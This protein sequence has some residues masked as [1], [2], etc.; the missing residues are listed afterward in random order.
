MNLLRSMTGYGRGE[1]QCPGKKF[2]LEIKA[3][4]HRYREVVV[5]VPRYMTMLEDPIRKYVQEVVTR[6][7]VDVYCSVEDGDTPVNAVK[8]DKSLAVAYYKAID[9]LRRYLGLTADI[10]IEHLISQPGMFSANNV[11][12]D[13]TQWWPAIEEALLVACQSLV[14]MRE[15]EG[16]ALLADL[17]EKVAGLSGLVKTVSDRAPEVVRSH[18][19]RLSRRIQELTGLPDIDAGRLAQ[20]VAFFAERSDISEELVRLNS[21]L[22]QLRDMLQTGG[23]VGRKLDFLVQEIFREINTIG[24]KAQDE[25]IIGLV[26]DFKGDLEKVREQIQNIE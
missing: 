6:G 19:V 17:T 3:V 26:V 11:G 23:A 15:I 25:S 22:A 24:S 21:H 8:V 2:T 10:R 9:E 13:P 1:S 18:Q 7:R 5:K 14:S 12:D 20:E 4:N 16:M